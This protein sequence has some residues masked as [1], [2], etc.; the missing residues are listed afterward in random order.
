VL[1]LVVP[2]VRSKGCWEFK[3]NSMPS[4]SVGSGPMPL[5]KLPMSLL[6]TELLEELDSLLK[7][8]LQLLAFSTD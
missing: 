4:W 6:L 5:A 2:G 1:T 8:S 7:S 3:L